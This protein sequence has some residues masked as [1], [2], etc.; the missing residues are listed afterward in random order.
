MKKIVLNTLFVISSLQ[1]EGSLQSWFEEGSVKGNV[2]YYYIETN[3]NKADGTYTSDHANSLGGQLSYTT[4]NSYGF[5]A[6][7]TFMTT[8]GFALPNSVDTSILARDNGVRIENSAS[9]N[10][11][12]DSFSVLGEMFIKYKID[13]FNALYGRKVISTPLIS[14]KEVRMLPSAVQGLFI[15]YKMENTLEIGLSNLTHFKQRTSDKFINI[16]EHALGSNTRL[17]TGA[18]SGE[19]IV[20]SAKY[21]NDKLK[22]NAYD[23]YIDNFMNSVY[24][25]A[26]FKEKVSDIVYKID[27]QYINQESVGYADNYLGTAGSITGAKQIGVD[28]IGLKFGLNYKESGFD[29]AFSKVLK[30]NDRH[31]SLVLP[32]DGTPLYTNTITSNNL[33]MSDYGKGLTSDSMYI[34]G[35]RGL[36]F[37]YAQGYD[38]TGVRGFKTALSYLNINND[39]FVHSQEDINAEVSY[40]IGNMSLALKGIWVKYNTSAAVNG[41]INP[42]D[43]R[44]KQY[45]VIANCKF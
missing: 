42:Q 45:R 36:M 16:V 34:G 1:A 41:T 15:D 7:A 11:A 20:L 10:A 12:Q 19:I 30:N 6:G 18:D 37:S 27:A 14:A 33:F 35:S 39:R 3:K 28:A 13:N 2:K 8:N 38:F 32:W 22:F 25:D 24:V 26:G 17:V 31:D 29:F 4:A 44:L 9:G 5:Q 21:G 43:D 23:Y 40:G